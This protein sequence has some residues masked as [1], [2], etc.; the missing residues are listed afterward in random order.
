[1]NVAI[2]ILFSFLL[3]SF[4]VSLLMLLLYDQTNY[5]KLVQKEE[6]KVDAKT[7]VSSAL[8]GAIVVGVLW[9]CVIGQRRGAATAFLLGFAMTAYSE[10]TAACLFNDWPLHVAL[11]DSLAGGSVFAVTTVLY[12]AISSIFWR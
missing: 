7:A 2:S 10:L 1:M 6:M 5:V 4:I 3:A 8:L 12:Y 11:L 9:I